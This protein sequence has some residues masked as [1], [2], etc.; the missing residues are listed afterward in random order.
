MVIQPDV[1]ESFFT[2]AHSKLTFDDKSKMIKLLSVL[3][4]EEN[5]TVEPTGCNKKFFATTLKILKIEFGNELT[6]V[7]STLCSVL[8]KWK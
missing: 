3:D 4:E 5:Y 6:A 8:T 7:N 2:R 1:I